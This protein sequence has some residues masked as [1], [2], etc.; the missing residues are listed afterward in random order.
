MT[1]EERRVF[2]T[3][4]DILAPR[5]NVVFVGINP[6][7]Y[8]V[9]RG[10]YFARPANRFWAALSLSRLSAAA[11][12]CLGRETLTPE[13]DLGLLEF[14]FG[15]TDIVKKP[16]ASAAE[17]RA[18]DFAAGAPQLRAR[19]ENYSPRIAC[20]QGATALRPFLRHALDEQVGALQFGL[21]PQRI[22]T[23]KLF[24][25]PNPSPA[26]ASFRLDALAGWFDLL[27]DAIDDRGTGAAS[28][29][30]DW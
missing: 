19:L 15:F 17:L 3:L 23:T 9:E 30:A 20:V 10:H 1:G 8:S 18:A 11:R 22:G 13:D 6:S 7:V 5:L 27:A 29:R 12:S 24:L 28:P 14:G 16:T 4:P 25:T 2:A 26:N 21:Q